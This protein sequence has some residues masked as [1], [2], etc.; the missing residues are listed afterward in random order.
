M[1][2][3]GSELEEE[4]MHPRGSELLRSADLSLGPCTLAN[5]CKLNY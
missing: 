1:H 4:V 3:R 2:L 5:V